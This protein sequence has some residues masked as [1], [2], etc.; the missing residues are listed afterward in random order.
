MLTSLFASVS[1]KIVQ[2]KKRSFAGGEYGAGGAS[3]HDRL[4]HSVKEVDVVEL[5]A[6]LPV[7]LGEQLIVLLVGLLQV[8]S[9]VVKQRVVLIVGQRA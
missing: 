4:D 2:E 5:I 1:G 8:H 6:E 9:V 7:V 3:G